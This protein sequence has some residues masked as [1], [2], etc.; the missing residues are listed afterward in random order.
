MSWARCLQSISIS[1]LHHRL[2]LSFE[3][4]VFLYQDAM[5]EKK[6]IMYLTTTPIKSFLCGISPHLIPFHLTFVNGSIGCE[7]TLSLCVHYPSLVIHLLK[8]KTM[9]SDWVILAAVLNGLGGLW[10]GFEWR[11]T[12]FGSWKGRRSIILKLNIIP[13]C[14]HPC[15][16][17]VG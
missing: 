14:S 17:K 11:K 2:T 15:R 9:R 5:R 10:E 3:H 12:N 1:S 4:D 7:H 6:D 8:L 13:Q 16:R